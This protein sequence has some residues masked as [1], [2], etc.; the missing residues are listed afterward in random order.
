MLFI[1]A[2]A[3]CAWV[4]SLVKFK[5]SGKKVD[6]LEPKTWISLNQFVWKWD[7]RRGCQEKLL[8]TIIG[9]SFQAHF[10]RRAKRPPSPVPGWM[11]KFVRCRHFE[12]KRAQI[13]KKV[14][15]P[16]LHQDRG[17]RSPLHLQSIQIHRR[18]WSRW[19]K[20]HLCGS[21]RACKK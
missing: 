17:R 4:H 19:N 21:S 16:W 15:P 10:K 12:S 18:N 2:I 13:P 6:F 1:I 9:E 3:G 7:S 11:Q 20:H 14:K 8:Q 5:G